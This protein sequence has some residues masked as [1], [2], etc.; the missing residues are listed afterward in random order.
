M[1]VSVRVGGA[2]MPGLSGVSGVSGVYSWGCHC[3]LPDASSAARGTPGYYG[4][5]TL[6]WHL[7]GT[8]IVTASTPAYWQWLERDSERG[9]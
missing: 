1:L 6:D 8:G 5:S 7:T 3:R 2:A 4:I 9:L